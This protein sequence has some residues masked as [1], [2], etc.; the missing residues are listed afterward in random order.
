MIEESDV[1]T[2]T[3]GA[4]QQACKVLAYSRYL[5]TP[6]HRP[7]LL[8]NDNLTR[9]LTLLLS[10]SHLGLWQEA[11]A[12]MLPCCLMSLSPA[13]APSR[14]RRPQHNCQHAVAGRGRRETTVTFAAARFCCFGCGGHRHWT[15][16]ISR[17]R[18][19]CSCRRLPI[20]RC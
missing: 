9:F 16:C 5:R 8:M 14:H 7:L 2:A 12:N 10:I 13:P 20:A 17:P 19:G 11:D 18:L 1:D 3:E 15:D 4:A 6:L